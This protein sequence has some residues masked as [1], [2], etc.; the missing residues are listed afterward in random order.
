MT[1]DS[2]QE[3]HRPESRLGSQMRRAPDRV[4]RSSYPAVAESVRAARNAAAEFARRAGATQQT[5]EAI[6]LSASEAAAN[7]VEHAYGDAQ[8]QNGEIEMTIELYADAFW[9]VVRDDGR[10]LSFGNRRPGLGHGFVWMAWFSDGMSLSA[11]PTGGLEVTL[12][13]NRG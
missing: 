9:L 6:R 13:F 8:G 5:E 7:V 11:S 2:T 1:L 3:M 10:G 12:R 4:F